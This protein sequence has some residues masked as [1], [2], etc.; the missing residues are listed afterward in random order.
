MSD[1]LAALALPR[2]L[3]VALLIILTLMVAPHMANLSP[4]VL[5]W[6]AIAM[7]WRVLALDH[8]RRLPGRATLLV[9]T[10]GA[11]VLVIGSSGLHDG[12]LTGTALLV[13]M[14]GLKLLEL[15]SRRDVHITLYLGFFLTLTQFLYNQSLWLAAYLLLG[16][17]ALVTVQLGL[18]RVEANGKQ[19]LNG[20]IR[21][22]AAA[23]PLALVGFLLFP[24]LHAPLWGIDTQRAI[25]GIGDEMTLGNIGQLSRSNA[26][27]FRVNFVDQV[28]PPAQ[29][30][31][32][33][34]VL[35]H[36]DGRRW[37]PGPRASRAA[38]TAHSEATPI[39]YE[40]TLEP[41]GA[42]W[43]FGLDS[44]TEPPPG[45]RLNRD[46]ALVAT[47]RVTRRYRYSAAS[48]PNYRLTRI[49]ADER[50]QAL[51]LPPTI[52][53]RVRAL[54]AA[55]QADADPREPMQFV[56]KALDYFRQQPFVYTL[57]PG[58]LDGDPIDAFLFDSR[59]GFC[60]HYAGSFAL[61]MRLG[62][63]P[64]RVVIGYQGGMKN[65]HADHWVVRQS[66]AHAWTEVWLPQRGWWRVDP[67]AAVAPERI[68]RAL[69]GARSQDQDQIIF[70]GDP[71]GL[72]GDLWREAIW[73][74][75]AV[76]FGWHRWVVG[77]DFDRQRYL[78]KDLGIDALRGT[79]LAI[80]LLISGGLAIGLA[81]L[82][83]RLP[84][85]RR[86]DPLPRLW[87]RFRRK[88]DRAG[89]DIPAWLGP[90]DLCARA[91]AAFPGQSGE[92]AAINRLY[93]QLRYGRAVNARQIGALR[94][95]IA[96][97]RLKAL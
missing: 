17:A 7:L 35:W 29:R 79:G 9:L 91:Q 83:G 80:A 20:A 88:L 24:R 3:L 92:L 93:V 41:T 50:R 8:P 2:R 27:A 64:S 26:T 67:T 19:Q 52:S 22:L 4:L 65:P 76:D 66:D 84:R 14:L 58:R 70:R 51:A 21:M 15:R 44:V 95:R 74:A 75:D 73:L 43:L 18:S 57:T 71:A 49:S 5:G 82:L 85:P 69:D 96:R 13:A 48:D 89:L 33:G 81:Y 46:Y 30:Y 10:L 59:R 1:A 39:R 62:G 63:I 68:E 16:V 47:Q 45:T 61:L 6:F 77:F 78:L 72:F 28:P 32:R 12:R 54:V 90:N 97:L 11:I 23:L 94:Q 56:R 87:Q 53:P 40:V 86:G 36:T 38:P 37:D 42:Y 60:E 34:P 55:W 31:W 25:T